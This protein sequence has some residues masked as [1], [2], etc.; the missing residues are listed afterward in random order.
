MNKNLIFVNVKMTSTRNKKC[1]TELIQLGAVKLTKDFEMIS[2]FSKFV[3]PNNSTLNEMTIARTSATQEV[4]NNSKDFIAVYEEFLVWAGNLEDNAFIFWGKN[5]YRMLSKELKAK[6]YK[7]EY[8]I[9]KYFNYQ[10]YLETKLGYALSLNDA[11]VKFKLSIEGTLK[12]ACDYALNI[13]KVYESAINS[14]DVNRLWFEGKLIRIIAELETINE[15]VKEYGFTLNMY[16]VD[17]LIDK[18]K[19]QIKYSDTFSIENRE[20]RLK[21][22]RISLDE[23][24]V[25]LEEVII[26]QFKKESILIQWCVMKKEFHK[27]LVSLNDFNK[28]WSK[29]SSSYQFF[30]RNRRGTYSLHYDSFKEIFRS[31]DRRKSTFQQ[32]HRKNEVG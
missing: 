28:L 26:E 31:I 30:N 11:I 6:K 29:L 16:A 32:A 19:L 9:S 7:G 23:I 3:K 20:D 15:H 22:I 12:N 4:I 14:S 24:E 18:C 21:E 1:T 10:S 13:C 5:D 8:V 27:S 17:E 2:I 25:E